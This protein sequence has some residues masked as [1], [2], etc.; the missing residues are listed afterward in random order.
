M[1]MDK[2]KNL[3]L[4]KEITDFCKER[5]KQP[6]CKA[7]PSKSFLQ[8]IITSFIALAIAGGVAEPNHGSWWA[9]EY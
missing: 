5:S 3:N 1:I 7:K 2:N 6:V 9:A 4:A 8:T